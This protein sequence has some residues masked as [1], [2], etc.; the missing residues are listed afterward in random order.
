ME[1][2]LQVNL[3]N[4][5]GAFQ[6]IYQAQTALKDEI[7]FDYYSMGN[8]EKNDV[9][10]DLIGMGSNIYEA[11]L[12]HNRLIGHI[13]LPFKFY[14]FL[15]KNI[16]S[17]VHINSDS[18]WKIL[19]YALPA[20]ILRVNNV[21]I[22]SHS[23]EI[24]GD[25]IKLKKMCHYIAKYMIKYCGTNFC[26]CSDESVK[27]MYGKVDNNK[28]IRIINNSVNAEKFKFNHSIREKIR[29]NLK[30]DDNYLIGTV[31]NFSYQKNPEFL[32]ELIEKL[33]EYNEKRYKL[34]FVGEGS[35]EYKIKEMVKQKK[36]D[37]YVIFYGKTDKVYEVLSAL[38][39]FIMPSRFEGLP[40]SGIEAQTNGLSCVFST[41]ITKE[42]K[43]TEFCE[44]I[45]LSQPLS[46]WCEIINSIK[47]N[48][49]RENA[50]KN[51]I[52]RNFDIKYTAKQLKDLYFSKVEDYI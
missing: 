5:G 12:R 20:K 32:V 4:S 35:G 15:K 36:L 41:E 6:L 38:D 9:Y 40:V 48:N 22:H 31:G 18:A 16:Y 1:K 13:L 51:T 2:V 30:V 28:N 39:I 45:N 24:N 37:D 33:N 27:W 50:Y 29:N 11:N 26:G 21:I 7:Q 23:S 8:F 46:E 17:T 25:H 44:Y 14:S 10:Y 34:I 52:N 42:V 47:L 43:I 3:E 19:M 49:N